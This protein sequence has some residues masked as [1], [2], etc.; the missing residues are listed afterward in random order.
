[1]TSS[2]QVRQLMGNW[3]PVEKIPLTLV[4]QFRPL[5]SPLWGNPVYLGGNGHNLVVPRGVQEADVG[6]GQ[7]GR[8]NPCSQYWQVLCGLEQASSF[9]PWF[10][11][12]VPFILG[13]RH[14]KEPGLVSTLGP[15]GS[16]YLGVLV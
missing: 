1:M 13:V 15:S 16:H 4:H 6:W 2:V 5:A 3:V 10:G 14:G 12:I 7:S 11:H 9:T 8:P